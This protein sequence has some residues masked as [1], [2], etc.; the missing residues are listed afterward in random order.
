MFSAI[1]VYLPIQINCFNLKEYELN[2]RCSAYQKLRKYDI[3]LINNS[4]IIK[5][6]N[7]LETNNGP[8]I[9]MPECK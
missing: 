4:L 3:N 5:V 6:K 2:E 1:F 8:R 9:I 7:H